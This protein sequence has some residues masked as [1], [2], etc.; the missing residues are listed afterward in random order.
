MSLL[1]ELVAETSRLGADA[2]DVEYKDRHEE[3][4]AMWGQVG[5]GIA[6]IPSSSLEAQALRRELY[7]IAK[8]QRR[9]IVGAFEYELRVRN[10]DSFG[11]DAFEVQLRRLSPQ[12]PTAR[13]RRWPSR[14][15][16]A[17]QGRP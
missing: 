5:A 12:A 13:K 2:L 3:V 9:L 11:E 8:K 17:D 16:L 14:E 4:A 1:E 7:A 6:R 15:R 10:R